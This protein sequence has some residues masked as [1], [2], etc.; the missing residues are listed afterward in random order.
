MD[1]IFYLTLSIELLGWVLSSL[2]QFL[3]RDF[4][5]SE[6][7]WA[8]LTW[9]QT[10]WIKHI[11]TQKTKQYLP[12][13]AAATAVASAVSDSVRP[14]RWPSTRLPRPWDSPGKYTGVGCHFLLQCMKVKS[15]SGVAQSCLTLSNLMDYSPPG[16]SIHWI[17]QARVLEWCAIAF[18][19]SPIRRLCVEIQL[20]YFTNCLMWVNF[21]PQSPSFS[22][23]WMCSMS[24]V[25]Y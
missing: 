7:S 10:A 8:L 9:E 3:F 15:E 24:F 20:L 12:S 1:F 2:V 21:V 16:S 22:K 19:I 18:S 13:T 6:R 23:F 11:L 14:H 25:L 4:L 17:F 5:P